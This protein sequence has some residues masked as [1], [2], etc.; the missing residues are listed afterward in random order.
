MFAPRIVKVPAPTL[1]KAPPTPVITP[2]KEEVAPKFPAV[3][4]AVPKL[5]EVEP[6]A[7]DKAPIDW[8]LLLRF[9]AAELFKVRSPLLGRAWAAK[10]DKIPPLMTVPPLYVFRPLLNTRVDEAFVL[11]ND[12]APETTPE[13][14]EVPVSISRVAAP[15][16]AV[17]LAVEKTAPVICK[18]AV[19]I[20]NEPALLPMFVPL[21]T[22]RVPALI[23][24]G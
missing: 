8:L 13:K 15:V 24:T 4:V 9:A 22:S 14:V 7:L 10:R 16:S 19:A 11:V 23:M 3:S 20:V 12:P 18:V 17:V 5:T 6:L 21:I 1:V 2:E